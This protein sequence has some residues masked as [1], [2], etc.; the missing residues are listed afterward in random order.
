MGGGQNGAARALLDQNGVALSRLSRFR[1]PVA[2][3]LA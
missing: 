3:R 2:L 1:Q